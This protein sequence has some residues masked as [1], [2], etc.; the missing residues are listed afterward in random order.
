MSSQSCA[1]CESKRQ[2]RALRNC[3]QQYLCRDHLKE[4]DDLLNIQLES[5]ADNI[6]QLADQL[7]QFNIDTIIE[8]IRNELDQW[9]QA[10]FES[11]EKIYHDKLNELN[12][13][14]NKQIQD[15]I[16][17]TKQ[18]QINVLKHIHDQDATNQ[19]IESLFSK[20]KFIQQEI[21]S[22]ENN[23]IQINIDPF[24]TNNNFINFNLNNESHQN[25]QFILTPIIQEIPSSDNVNCI[26]NNDRH[27]VKPL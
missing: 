15:L 12:E 11:I 14:F 9:K 25:K 24:I 7:Q 8:P 22:L 17:Q 16:E 18:I 4:H 5:L 19:Q 10:A 13:F 1:I 2:S 20:I 6:N 21:N 3:C 26:T 27:T 23:S